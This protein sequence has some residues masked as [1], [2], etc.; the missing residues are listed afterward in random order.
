MKRAIILYL[1]LA[2][3]ATDRV[4][5]RKK[6]GL[7]PK[8]SK[9]GELLFEDDF[10]EKELLWTFDSKAGEWRIVRKALVTKSIRGQGEG[11][12]YSTIQRQFTPTENVMVEMK[13]ILPTDS[14]V[15]F[16]VSFIGSAR[17][18]RRDAPGPPV[19]GQIRG[20]IVPDENT[21]FIQLWNKEMGEERLA[22]KAFPYTRARPVNLL[23]EAF[24]GKF[25][26]TADGRTVEWEQIGGEKAKKFGV[27]VIL[28]T[29]KQLQ[30][31]V[32]MDDVK[33]WEALP[34]EQE[35]KNRKKRR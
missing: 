23:F 7:E 28:W 34:K 22:K 20:C 2:F 31:V 11:Y 21:M 27:L 3:L 1:A 14:A 5:A 26:F 18:P 32:A 15:T 16:S 13:A 17:G 19:R 12:T 10:S 33:V 29:H 24:E 6:K 30:D 9:R 4:E 8:I 25:V 35:E